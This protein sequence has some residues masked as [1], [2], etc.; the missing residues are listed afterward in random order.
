MAKKEGKITTTITCENIAPL[1]NLHREIKSNSLKM[2]IYAKNGSGKTF[3]SRLFRLTEK[4]QNNETDED[5]KKYHPDN[6]ITFEEKKASFSFKIIDKEGEKENINISFERGNNPDISETQYIYHTFNQDYVNQNIIK[7]DYD[8][9][10]NITGYILGSENIDIKDEE[11]NLEKIKEEGIKLKSELKD[12]INLFVAQRIDSIRDVKRI[13]EYDELTYENVFGGHNKKTFY[14]DKSMDELFSDYK[15]VK[16]IHEDLSDIPYI[17]EF[18]INENIFAAIKNNLAKEYTLSKLA[19]EFKQKI[20]RKQDFIEAGLSLL[21]EKD[22]SSCPFCEQHLKQ[23]AIDLID[24]YNQFITDTEVLID[25]EFRSNIAT[26]KG[27]IKS[28]KEAENENSSISNKFDSYKARYIPSSENERLAELKVEEI[29]EAVQVIIN[30]IEDKL[31]NISMIVEVDDSTME[32][33]T[34]SLKTFYKTIDDNNKKITSINNKKNDI[35]KISLN[36]RRNICKV[37]YNYLVED[38]GLKIAEIKK[39]RENYTTLN[40][41]IKKKKEKQK[42]EKRDKVAS[43]IEKVLGYFFDDKYS[44][45]EDTFRLKFNKKLLEEKQA[46]N[47]LSDGEKNI[48]AF[49][50]YIGDT[51]LKVDHEDDYK[52]LFFIIDDPIS[53]MDYSYVYTLCGVIRNLKDIIAEIAKC[54]K[55]IIIFT[56]NSEFMRILCANNIVDKQLILDKGNLNDF[57]NNLAIPYISHLI[58][59]Y[60]VAREGHIPTHTTANSIRHI[61][62]MLSKLQNIKLCNDSIREYIR[63]NFPKDIQ[64]YSLIQDLSHGAVRNS[65]PP[66]TNDDFKDVCENVILHINEKFEGQ[67]KYC[68]SYY[69]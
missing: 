47:V 39:L 2:G 5:E 10:G 32:L 4:N 28:L 44:L 43:T 12:K 42:A 55:K 49:A 68:E 11:K 30:K 1:K 17:N 65:Q 8:K 26:L 63:L 3:I 18:D 51:Y 41:K 27:I 31:R 69:E 16:S 53:S 21:K 19:D 40:N 29:I 33:I 35:N 60:G 36:V 13:K 23:N 66:I 37:A 64:S 52:K 38:N 20:K 59:I 25:K 50:Y 57:N 56:H 24:K 34:D 62:E 67:I 48:V 22:R 6:F 54:H 15:K 61:I 45:D 9:D 58:D 7:D 14:V 46:K